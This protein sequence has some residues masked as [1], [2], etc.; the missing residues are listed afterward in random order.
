MC[1]G[2]SLTEYRP[3]QEEDRCRLQGNGDHQD[4]DGCFLQG[5]EHEDEVDAEGC[6]RCCGSAHGRAGDMAARYGVF[7]E[8]AWNL[9]NSDNSSQPVKQKSP[10]AWGLYDM[11]GNV[12]EWCWDWSGSYDPVASLN[13]QGPDTGTQRS[14]RGG[15]WADP[16]RLTRAAY[17][18]ASPPRLRD[19]HIGFR[20]ARSW[21]GSASE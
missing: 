11:L 20:A 3:G 8:I 17:R 7:Y 12:S 9:T 6:A 4:G 5:G 16:P 19:N 15:N 14:Y 18:G 1:S 10:N 2:G 21:L 13:P